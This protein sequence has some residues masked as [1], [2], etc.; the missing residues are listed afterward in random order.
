MTYL[1]LLEVFDQCDNAWDEHHH[2]EDHHHTDKAGLLDTL[3]V[4]HLRRSSRAG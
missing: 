4:D 3:D 2:E 1:E